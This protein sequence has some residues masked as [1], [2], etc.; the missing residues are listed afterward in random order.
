MK[1]IKKDYARGYSGEKYPDK[2]KNNPHAQAFYGVVI[3]ELKEVKD[4]TNTKEEIMAG[5]ALNIDSV[6]IEN[7]KID[8]HN[9][10]DVHK[11]MEQELDDLIYDFSKDNDLNLSFDQIDK[12]IE[13]LIKVALKRY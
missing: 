10:D 8:W 6:F 4:V 11:K 7:C 1:N 5:L 9:N 13:Q 2:I 12:I 3:D